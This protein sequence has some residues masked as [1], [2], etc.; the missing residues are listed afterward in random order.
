[1][2]RFSSA[3]EDVER[4]LKDQKERARRKHDVWAQIEEERRKSILD[5]QPELWYGPEFVEADI[6]Q[7][8]FIVKPFFPSGGLCL[9]HGKRGIGK[10]MLTMALTRAVATGEPFLNLFETRQGNVVVIQLDMV[11]SVYHDRLKNAPEYYSFE[12]WYTLTGVASIARATSNTTWVQEVIAAQPSLII[13]DTLRKAHSWPENSSDTPARFY[14]KLRE[15]F[16]YTAVVMVHHDRKTQPDAIGLDSSESFRG[17]GAWLDDVDCGI[18]VVSKGKHVEMN[19]SKVRTCDD[20]G[21]VPLEVDPDRLVLRPSW[22]SPGA[23]KIGQ[24]R[25]QARMYLVK[26]PDAEKREI[27]QYLVDQH[28][29]PKHRASKATKQVM[30]TS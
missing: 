10:S 29:Q 17:S 18:H 20:P 3:E 30:D 21:G 1:M 19:F 15:L 12:N 27:Y 11:E 9:L 13:I 4:W 22:N 7:P 28:G 23:S 26:N 14:T 16:G 24:A 8:P 6:P 5:K 25:A 2:S